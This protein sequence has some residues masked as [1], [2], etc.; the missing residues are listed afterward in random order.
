MTATADMWGVLVRNIIVGV[1]FF[2]AGLA[3][4]LAWGINVRDAIRNRD[5]WPLAYTVN[6]T[7]VAIVILLVAE[8]VFRLPSVPLTWKTALYTFAILGFAISAFFIVLDHR[9][10]NRRSIDKDKIVR[11]T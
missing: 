3:L 4:Y 2:A 10:R 5:P 8:A 6:R 7:C 9:R 1:T 11:G